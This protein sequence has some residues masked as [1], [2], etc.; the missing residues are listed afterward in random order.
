M[1]HDGA[2]IKTAG[3]RLVKYKFCEL[4]VVDRITLREYIKETV[5]D[6]NSEI[7]RKH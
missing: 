1:S 7:K 5:I 6:S 2:F 4:Q 3:L